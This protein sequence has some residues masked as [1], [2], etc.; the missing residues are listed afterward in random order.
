[1]ALPWG[2]WPQNADP[3][4]SCGG[5]F[6]PP[7]RP[8]ANIHRFFCTLETLQKSTHFWTLS[9]STPGGVKVDPWPPQYPRMDPG[10]ENI[11]KNS[12]FYGGPKT[13]RA[14]QEPDLDSPGRFWTPFWTPL[15]TKIDPWSAQDRPEGSKKAGPPSYLFDPVPPWT[16]PGGDL[17]SKGA[18]RAISIDFGSHLGGLRVDF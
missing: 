14:T 10:A 15:G 8:K 12:V 3:W 2:A 13:P 1:M 16:R 7:G 6:W 9:K 11:D 17:C 5:F 18:L 4:W